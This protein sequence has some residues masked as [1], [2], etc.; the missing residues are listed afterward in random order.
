MQEDHKMLPFERGM[1]QVTIVLLKEARHKS[2]LRCCKCFHVHEVLH[3]EIAM[4]LLPFQ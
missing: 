1:T 2:P 3:N 4:L